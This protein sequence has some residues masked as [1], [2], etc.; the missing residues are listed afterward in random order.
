MR[1]KCGSVPRKLGGSFTCQALRPLNGAIFNAENT[2]DVEVNLRPHGRRFFYF[3][4][5]Y[6]TPGEVREFLRGGGPWRPNS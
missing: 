6:G 4:S 2:G 3:K 5:I 1:E